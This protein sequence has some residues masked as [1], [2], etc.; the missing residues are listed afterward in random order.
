MEPIKP[1]EKSSVVTPNKQ[2]QP[3]PVPL[4]HEKEKSDNNITDVYAVNKY[5]QLASQY[6]LETEIVWSALKYY[7]NNDW[8]MEQS[9]EAACAEWDILP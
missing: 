4:E 8:S 2:Q 6:E 7:K 5:L 9:L 1:T 3:P